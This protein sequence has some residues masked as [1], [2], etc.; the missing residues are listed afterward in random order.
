[1]IMKKRFIMVVAMCAAALLMVPF[2]AT[3]KPGY[4]PPHRPGCPIVSVPAGQTWEV[5]ETTKLCKL[6]IA[7]GATIIAP[8]G[9]SLT[10]TVNGVETGQALVTTAGVDTAFVPGTYCGNI[11]LTVAEA[12][13]VEFQPAGPP[14]TPSQTFPFRQALYVDGTGV[15]DAKSVLAAVVGGWL[16]DD[17]AKNIKIT[18]TGECFDGVFVSNGTF[19]LEK[20]KINFT[21]NG[22]SDF[23]GDGAAIVGGTPMGNGPT[24]LIVDGADIFN[25]GVV[26]TGVVAQ[27]GSNVIVKNSHIQTM[28][29][30]IPAD[31][32]PTV[33]MAQMRSVPW[34]LSLSGNVRATNLLGQSTKASYI[35]S[36]IGSE[37]WGVLSSDSGQDCT[38]TAINSMIAITGQDG[39]GSYAIGNAHERF[40]GC[41]FNVGTYATI[42]RGGDVHYGDSDAAT[43]AQ[44]N[45]DLGLGLTA[46]ELKFLRPQR[47]IVN[48]RRF[49]VMWHGAGSAF[50]SGGT[51]FNTKETTFLDKGQAIEITVDGSQGAK[52][53][54]GNGVIFQLMDDDDPGPQMPGMTNTGIYDEPTG[55]VTPDVTHNPLLFI[56]GTDAGATFSNIKLK[57]DFYN[58]TRGG[59][60]QGPFGPPSSISRNLGLTLDNAFL[61]GVISASTAHH[62]LPHIE[63]PVGLGGVINAGHTEDYKMLGEVTNT[64][65]A[66][67][68]NGM[69]VSLTNGSTWIVE[70]T[71]Y[72]TSLFI[73]D[74]SSI[75]PLFGHT[76]S[77][78]VNGT[79]TD[80]LPGTYSGDIVLTVE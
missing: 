57:G 72:L 79:A 53:R 22:R 78:T 54:P 27:G 37:G 56:A 49:G 44:L 42:N 33:D 66:A 47:T 69:I 30:V 10:M 8:E 75:V 38:L 76:L 11:V 26:R 41:T 45:T 46:K 64:P 59:L 25:R 24:T 43:V 14:G 4:H 52:L 32:T 71:C 63:Y 16:T 39:Y 77:M 60:V 74:T 17:E 36:Y 48:S 9:Y 7:E 20:A 80:I 19:N 50:I 23:A 35:N 29:G 70:D 58:G 62:L 1:M 65:S 6:T 13:E 12:N 28:N 55:P 3:G 18:S 67:V 21:G 2:A 73:E 68:N 31:Y 40:L 51:I 15:V 5:L 61:R 34:M